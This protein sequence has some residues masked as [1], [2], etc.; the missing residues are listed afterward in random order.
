V[1]GGQAGAG[2][3]GPRRRLCLLCHFELKCAPRRVRASLFTEVKFA[4]KSKWGLCA[5]PPLQ[6]SLTAAYDVALQDIVHV[7]RPGQV[8]RREGL[9][10]VV[11]TALV[12]AGVNVA[13]R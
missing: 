4:I 8:P 2:H 1:G 9:E 3:R 10:P 11:T 13:Y 6:H 7:H 12:Q 5:Q